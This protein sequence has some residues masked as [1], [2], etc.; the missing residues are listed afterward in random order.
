MVVPSRRVAADVVRA[1]VDEQR[2]TIVPGGTDHLA[3]P[4]HEATQVLL[5][6]VGVTGDFLLT[7]C[8]LEPRKNLERLASAV[9]QVRPSLPRPWP[10]VVVGPAGWGSAPRAAPDAGVVFTGRVSEMALS[11]LYAAAR[12]FA[13]VPL[14]E[15][16]GLPP[17]EAMRMG[18]PAVVARGVP[19]V[20]DLDG[21]A[22]PPARLVDPL[23]VEDIAAGVFDVLTD[24]VLRS[25]LAGRGATYA[26]ARTWRAVADAHV[27]LWSTPP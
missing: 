3:E 1:G 15:G 27:R 8:T 21:P 19:S 7:V 5:R 26:K 25:D 24:D 12:A 13:Y 22:D 20:H 23:D 18:T 6:Q 11:G 10:L 4:D 9:A 14:T 2:I 16:Y 17:L